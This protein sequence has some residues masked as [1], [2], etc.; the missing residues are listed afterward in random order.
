VLEELSC[1]SAAVRHHG[2]GDGGGGEGGGDEDKGEGV[3]RTWHSGLHGHTR[4]TALVHHPA[5]LIK[6]TN[7]PPGHGYD[8][9]GGD[10]GDGEHGED[11]DLVLE[12]GTRTLKGVS[13]ASFDFCNNSVEMNKTGSVNDVC[14]NIFS[15]GLIKVTF[16]PLKMWTFSGQYSDIWAKDLDCGR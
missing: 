11:V 2:P 5:P 15:Q 3:V 8:D 16:Q 13:N 6:I 9:G 7:Q 14:F 12:G 10:E 4:G 1:L